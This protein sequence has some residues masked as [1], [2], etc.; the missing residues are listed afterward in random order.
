MVWPKRIF[1][2]IATNILIMLVI[3]TLVSLLGIEPYLN[4][5]GINYQS[6]MIMCLLWGMGGS[7]ISLW[8]SKWMVKMSMGLQPIEPHGRLG[9]LV[10]TV[11]RVAKQAGLSTMPEVYIY[12]SPEP[13]A[14]ATGPSRSNSLV[15]VSTGLLHHMNDDEVEGVLAHEVAHIANGD[16]VTMTLIQGVMNAFVMFFAR[17]ATFAIDQALRGK[18]DDRGGGLGFFG[19]MMVSNL[20]QV[21]FGLLAAPVVMYFSRWREFRADAGSAAMVG[22]DKMIAALRALQR[23]QERIQDAP[24]PAKNVEVMQIVSKKSLIEL[25]S[26]HPPLEKRI[27]A[28]QS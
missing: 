2:F 4:G 15:A 1:F 13:N 26:S 12:D 19:Y 20:F 27:R 5:N 10:Q 14:F 25:F 6:L 9:H 18:D 22:R 3:S 24:T 7:F 23:M 16:M 28:L 17:I 21:V 11:H 8:M